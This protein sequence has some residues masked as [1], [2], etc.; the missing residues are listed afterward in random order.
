MNELL[1][2]QEKVIL[3]LCCGTG[4]QLKLLSKNGFK[5]LYC[6]DISDSM[7]KIARRNAPFIKIYN[8]NA[9]K[10]SFNYAFF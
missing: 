4:N 8:E 9:T 2:Y 7:L 10:T 1:K 6:L 3:D 5:N